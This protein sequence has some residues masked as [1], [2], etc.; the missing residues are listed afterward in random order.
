MLNLLRKR[1]TTITLFAPM[2]GEILKLEDVPDPV[3]AG[4]MIGDGIAINPVDGEVWAPCDG[5]IVQVFPTKHAIGIRTKEGIDIL[6]HIGIDTVTLRG[7]GFK[8]FI[9]EGST[10]KKGDKLLEV[11]LDF[12]KENG[13]SIITPVIITN[14]NKVRAISLSSGKVAGKEDVLMEL[15]C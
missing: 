2:S 3:F 11:D 9:S 4:K 6:L 10:V 1:N 12:I 14:M 13:K 7:E 15:R 8:A 5:R